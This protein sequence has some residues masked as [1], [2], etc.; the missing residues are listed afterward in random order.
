VTANTL[1]PHGWRNAKK[2][3]LAVLTVLAMHAGLVRI[4]SDLAYPLNGF[5]FRTINFI[6]RRGFPDHLLLNESYG[7]P[8]QYHVKTIAQGL[9]LFAVGMFLGLWAKLRAERQKPS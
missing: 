5:A 4:L 8:W 7:P 3:S 6:I 2:Y 1:L 9:A